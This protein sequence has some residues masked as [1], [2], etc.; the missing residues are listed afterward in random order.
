MKLAGNASCFPNSQHQLRYTFGVQVGRAFVQVK[1]YITDEGTN[2]TD[3]PALI[4]VLE[5]AF[6][7]PDHGVTAERKLEILKQ[8]HRD[9]ST[10]YAEFQ[11][12]ATKV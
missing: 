2:L 7:D 8:T 11:R 9:F 10:Y 1:A 5:T 6:R 3:V 12:C 4:I